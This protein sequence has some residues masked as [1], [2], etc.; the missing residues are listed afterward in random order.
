MPRRSTARSG[1]IAA[2]QPEPEPEQAP[3]HSRQQAASWTPPATYTI[4]Q[5]GGTAAHASQ[6][7]ST[8]RPRGRA[9]PAQAQPASI[10]NRQQ[11]H[12]SRRH[13]PGRDVQRLQSGAAPSPSP[14]NGQ[15]PSQ[16]KKSKALTPYKA[17]RP[18]SGGAHSQT[19]AA[20]HRPAESDRRKPEKRN[21]S[22]E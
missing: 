18:D 17:D 20:R 4:R 5:P 1:S 16:R 9:S 14:G 7:R 12:Q 6:G 8:S 15:H 3:P 22:E 13:P 10:H 11:E 21:Q 19:S 2:T